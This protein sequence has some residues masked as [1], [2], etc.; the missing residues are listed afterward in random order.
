MKKDL[1][2]Y[3]HIPFCLRKCNYC[4]FLSFAASEEAH[5]SYVRQLRNEI[6]YRSH[7]AM[8]RP[9]KSIYIGG[10]TPSVIREKLIADILRTLKV[11]FRV[12]AD[13][14]IT[15]ECNPSSVMR[16]KFAV[17]KEAGI[18]RLSIGLQ[19]TNNAELKMLGRTHSFEE[20]LGAYQS[21]R[22][23]HF[24]NISIDLING[25]PMQS[26]KSWRT[27]LLEACMM[28][29]EH[30]SVYD[31]IVEEGT[32]FYEMQK[33]ALLRLPDE[34]EQ[35]IFDNLK[36]EFFAK[37]G[38]QRYEISNYSKPGKECRHNIGYWTQVEYLGLGLG[39]SSYF[40]ET[41]WK[42]I[43]DMNTYLNIDFIYGTKRADEV[44]KSEIHKLSRES[45]M[46]EFMFLGLRLIQGISKSK[47]KE[48]FG[49]SIEKIYGEVLDK[50]IRLG[51]MESDEEGDHLRLTDRGINVSNVILSEFLL[52]DSKKEA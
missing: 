39:A 33:R 5:E 23:E 36:T 20:F 7:E 17:Y 22:M 24:D 50:N 49:V 27:T 38:F 16:H 52:E 2:L 28:K 40:E 9:V 4:D 26:L 48:R 32:P 47:F 1:E 13:A 15:I 35:E 42:N 19:S 3:I 37:Y 30:I 21:A 46:E 11:Y 12:E 34:K 6:A 25:I 43:R 45:M 14:E 8:D 10:G 31:L 18:N 41:R 51:F 44:L 29:P